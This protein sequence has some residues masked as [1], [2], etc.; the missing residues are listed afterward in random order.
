M[1]FREDEWRLVLG[2]YS[3]ARPLDIFAPFD[4]HWSTLTLLVYKPL[5]AITGARS[6][7]PY[8]GVTLLIYLVAVH[9]LW[10]VLRRSGVDPWIAALGAAAVMVV[11]AAWQPMFWALM[12]SYTLPV[13]FALGGVLL[14]D[15]ERLTGRRQAAVV[16][17]MLLAEMCVGAG[18]A[19]MVVPALVVAMRHGVRRGLATVAVP[20]L[21]FL[22]WLELAGGHVLD[23]PGGASRGEV[24]AVARFVWDGLS[25]S[26]ATLAGATVLGSVAL[27]ALAA[28]VGVRWRQRGVP[29]AIPACAAGAAGLFLLTAVG[30][31]NGGDATTPRYVWAGAVLLMP[32]VALALSDMQWWVRRRAAFAPGLLAAGLL[33]LTA[34]GAT[35]LVGTVSTASAAADHSHQV[36]LAAAA[37]SRT[38]TALADSHP[39]S[40]Q[41]WAVTLADV[42]R[43]R[44]SGE[45]PPPA[46]I[47]PA[48]AAETLLHIRVAV[49]GTPVDTV[50][51]ATIT[52]VD[53]ATARSDGGCTVVSGSGPGYIAVGVH[54]TGPAALRIVAVTPQV[55]QGFLAGPVED[56]GDMVQPA[57]LVRPG[58][59]LYL[60]DVAPGSTVILRFLPGAVRLCP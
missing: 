27:V 40:D 16:A 53:G 3:N 9:L 45:L 35:Q 23:H 7:L 10:R 54:F 38:G 59:T 20:A 50:T 2:H 14:A 19:L 33:A 21:A 11:G 12:I 4:V 30:R 55:V 37:L 17:T 60:D 44:D 49:S 52:A 22:G 25:G 47:P 46:H 31:V 6:Y 36:L 57:G 26:M 48:V 32:G 34:H 1:W 15:T 51:P 29:A 39:E 5:V 24:G 56:P 13:A 18:L 58:A 8:L 28:W 43:L 41:A 42:V